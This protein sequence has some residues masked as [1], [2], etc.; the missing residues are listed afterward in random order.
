MS[1]RTNNPTKTNKDKADMGTKT[2]IPA[3]KDQKYI[4]VPITSIQKELPSKQERL[5]K[6]KWV[7]QPKQK[8]IMPEKTDALAALPLKKRL[9][10]CISDSVVMQ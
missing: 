3:Q 1:Q 7:W 9:K 2:D 6:T 8:I 10:Q 5:P 4:W